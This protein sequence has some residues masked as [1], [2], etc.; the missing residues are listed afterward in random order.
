M[1]NVWSVF[2]YSLVTQMADRSQTSTA[3]SVYL[4]GGLQKMLTLPAT[5]LLDNF[6]YGATTFSLI[7]TKKDISLR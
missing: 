6:P 3:L 2:L 1:Q 5:V 7:F 4:Y